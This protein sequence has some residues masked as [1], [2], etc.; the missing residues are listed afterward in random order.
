MFQTNNI[1]PLV[2][3]KITAAKKIHH[4]WD[5]LISS[6]YQ[7]R[8]FLIHLE[9]Y[10]YCDQRY[11]VGSE[12]ETYCIG[13]VVYSLKINILTFSKYT[14]NIPMTV[15]GIPASVDAEGVVGDKMLYAKMISHIMQHEK[16]VVLC[17]NY[18]EPLQLARVVEMQTLP[19]LIFNNIYD[20]FS[21]YLSDLRHSRR[22]RIIRAKKMGL[23][24][25]EVESSCASFTSDHY[26]QYLN[27]ISR[28][29][30]KLEVL[31]QEFFVNLPDVFK[32][33]SIYK[34]NE[35]LTWHIT[36]TQNG[37]YYFLF[38]GMNYALRDLY[39]SYCNNLI[40][41]IRKAIENKCRTINLGQTA[42]VSKIRF[43]A[44]S[45]QKKMFLYH[46]NVFIN[47]LFFL[48][49]KIIEY[50]TRTKEGTVFKNTTL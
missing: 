40:S 46:S 24:L 10:N 5:Y 28:T 48:F 16:G 27:I 3:E 44:D 12:Y 35:L 29:K 43:G 22:R 20:S 30:T 38:G 33:Y 32:L 47:N 36:T 37:V 14:L 50:K 49:K 1:N 34:G 25:R 18:T 42:E 11:Y 19:T 39:D 7:E 8:D 15:I 17:L 41:I 2:I 13:S 45:Y 23:G 6:A 31:T 9:K 26:E 21:Q 4:C